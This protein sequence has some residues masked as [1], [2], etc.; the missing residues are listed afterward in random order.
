MANIRAGSCGTASRRDRGVRDSAM[1]TTLD[2]LVERLVRTYDPESIILF[3]SHAT[4]GAREGSDIDLLVVKETDKRPIDRRVEV[5]R[6]LCDRQIPLD[7][8][9]YTPREM[10]DLYMAGSPFV[11]EV[12]QSGRVLYARSATAAWLAEAQQKSAIDRP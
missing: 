5:E 4:G 9:V 12:V 1:L 11:E 7:I 3:G 10:R 2:D 6:L 8:Q